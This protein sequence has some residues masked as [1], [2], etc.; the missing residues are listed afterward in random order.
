MQRFLEKGFI[1]RFAGE[2]NIK[3][4]FSPSL[5]LALLTPCRAPLPSTSSPT[6]SQAQTY[7]GDQTIS[8]TWDLLK[9]ASSWALCQPNEPEI[10]RMEPSYLF[11]FLLIEV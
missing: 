10:L 1:L 7:T 4:M 3:F 2:K 11:L 9:N 5:L 8:L 6:P